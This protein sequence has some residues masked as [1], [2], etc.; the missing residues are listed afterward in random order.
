MNII[1]ASA[2]LSVI[3]FSGPVMADR[4]FD[5]LANTIYHVGHG[6]DNDGK[7]LIGELVINRVES[8]DFPDTICGVVYQDGQFQWTKG[9]WPITMQSQYEESVRISKEL[10]NTKSTD[11]MPVLYYHH[12]MMPRP[13]WS[14]YRNRMLR[15]GEYIYYE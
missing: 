10:L 6:E 9:T 3:I 7:R 14:Y 4:E 1:S 13:E 11:M 2:L 8:D 12:Y 15:H 5:C